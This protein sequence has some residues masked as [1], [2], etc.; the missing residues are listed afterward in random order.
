MNRLVLLVLGW[1]ALLIGPVQAWWDA[2]HMLV[3]A[4]AW[5]KMS[6]AARARAGDLLKRNPMYDW[7]MAGAPAGQEDRIA[8]I[9]ASTW[10]DEIKKRDDYQ[11]D[12]PDDGNRPPPGAEASQNIGY[13]DHFMHKYW[14]FVDEP[15][16]PDE[17]LLEDPETPNAQTQIAAFRATLS[18]AASDDV[19]SYDLVWLLHLVGDVHQPLH[20][21][22]RFTHD[23]PHG[24]AGGNSVPIDC[25]SL[26]STS[27]LHG[28]WDGL[29]GNGKDP[30]DAINSF[31]VLPT[32][33]PQ[34]AAIADEAVWIEESF[35]IAKASVYAPP[36]GVGA[37]PFPI[38]Q[39]YQT[40]A[41]KIAQARVALAGARLANLLNDALR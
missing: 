19:K 31:S 13:A 37:G 16:S 7:L 36:I 6:L 32:P 20:A 35:A 27:Q 29:F 10:A 8:F 2:G 15:F 12:G 39:A 38:T 26:C 34:L 41:F 11:S 1:S 28:F 9:R 5:D 33:D 22:S 40:D 17:T 4:V 24:D 14:H 30:Q 25:S 3:A 21:T 18:S 23:L